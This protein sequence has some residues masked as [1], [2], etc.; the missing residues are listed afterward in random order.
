MKKL[1][2][3]LLA[4]ILIFTVSASV[5]EAHKP[6]ETLPDVPDDFEPVSAEEIEQALPEQKEQPE[7]TQPTQ[8]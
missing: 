3:V 4:F 2:S 8:E 1:L 6:E 5:A 7:E